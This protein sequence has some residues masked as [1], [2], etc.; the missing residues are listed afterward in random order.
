MSSSGTDAKNFENEIQLVVFKL[1]TEEYAIEIIKVSEIRKMTNITRVPRTPNYYLGVMNLR[2][3]VLPVLDLKKRLNLPE[4]T[5]TEDSR[6]IILKVDDVP[7][8]ITVD[9]VSEVTTIYKDNIEPPS[10][11]D[12]NVE[13]KFITGVG[14]YNNRLLIMLNTNEIINLAND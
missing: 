3:S 14:K 1:A 7:F 2:G 5:N 8:G 6:I 9:A 12:T 4:S 13:R 10:S 11:V